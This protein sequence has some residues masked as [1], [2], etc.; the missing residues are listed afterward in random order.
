MS[1]PVKGS[2]KLVKLRTSRW[3]RLIATQPTDSEL[4]TGSLQLDRGATVCL[5]PD[6][7]KQCECCHTMV[8]V[9]PCNAAEDLLHSPFGHKGYGSCFGAGN[10]VVG[11]AMCAGDPDDRRS[12]VRCVLILCGGAAARHKKAEYMGAAA[13][14]KEALW[15]RTLPSNLRVP[16]DMITLRADIRAPS[17]CSSIRNCL[18]HFAR[19]RVHASGRSANTSCFHFH[20]HTV[21][22][23]T[24][25][26]QGGTAVMSAFCVQPWVPAML[27]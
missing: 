6:L 21:H 5:R 3:I 12:T 22:G 15:L 2:T 10:S 23:C 19:E 24:R 9:S 25:A 18:I 1:V 20:K 27:P 8:A 7:R 14:T 17:S 11:N 16:V 26:D 4:L 13:A